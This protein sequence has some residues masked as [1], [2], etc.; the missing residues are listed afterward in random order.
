MDYQAIKEI[1]PPSPSWALRQLDRIVSALRGVQPRYPDLD[2]DV[3]SD[4][5]KRDMGFMD[6]REQ[7]RDTNLT[8]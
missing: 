6:G 3:M 5:M 2:L 4:Y 7:Y 8:R 1:S